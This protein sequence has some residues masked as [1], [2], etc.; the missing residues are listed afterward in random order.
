MGDRQNRS[1]TDGKGWKANGKAG[2]TGNGE[3]GGRPAERA[4]A[5]RFIPVPRHRLMEAL[6]HESVWPGTDPAEVKTFF[7]YLVQWRHLAYADR[8]DDLD[9]AYAP[10]NPD[11]DDVEAAAPAPAALARAKADLIRLVRELL[12]RANYKEI[13]RERL[14]QVIAERNPYGLD[15]DVDLDEYQEL[16]VFTRGEYEEDLSGDLIEKVIGRGKTFTV[17]K[18]KRLFVLM[19]LKSADVRAAELQ[20]EEG[21]S[22]KQ[23]KKAVRKARKPLSLHFRP[24]RIYL[25]LFRGIPRADL[26]MLLPNTRIRFKNR[27]KLTLGVTAGGGAVG[28]ASKLTAAAALTPAG[29]GVAAFALLGVA[30]QQF[31]RFMQVRTRYMMQLAQSLYFQN[32]AN[33]QGVLALLAERGEDE[34]IKEELLLYTLI[35]RHGGSRA[36]LGR[37]KLGI[38]QYL[39]ESFGV[40]VEFDAED[41]LGRL[42]EEGVVVESADGTLTA[43]EPGK[44]AL[45]IDARWDIYLD[46]I[47]RSEKSRVGGH[48]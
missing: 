40:H 24:D 19:Q 6:W 41:A 27:D 5:E 42:I 13:P 36:E 47:G 4:V 8:V 23:A 45:H 46:E 48:G 44:A 26:E 30:G 1:G 18:F 20:R 21:I 22:E 2:R 32:L 9:T 34:D 3:A 29:F 25:K 11:S 43:L 37:A 38:E 39:L 7:R 17:T 12:E 15:F 14:E 16:M 35:A 28:V 10:F 33:N 31:N